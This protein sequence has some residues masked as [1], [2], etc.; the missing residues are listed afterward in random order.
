MR[1]SKRWGEH[2]RR[3]LRSS[4]HRYVVVSVTY[5]IVANPLLEVTARL[6][7][8]KQDLLPAIGETL[9]LA[10]VWPLTPLVLGLPFWGL[11]TIAAKVGRRSSPRMAVV[12]LVS[13]VIMLTALYCFGHLG[14]QESVAHRRWTDAA[15]LIGLLPLLSVPVLIVVHLLGLVLVGVH[16]GLGER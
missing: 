12:A 13:G 11:G 4:Q 3:V 7:I 5:F 15:L 14:A 6:A 1:L 10:M 16:A 8:G 2:G 9:Y